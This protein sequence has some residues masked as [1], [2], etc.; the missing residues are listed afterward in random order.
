MATTGER[1]ITPDRCSGLILHIPAAAALQVAGVAAVSEAASVVVAAAV[2]A[3][4]EAEALAAAEPGGVIRSL[5]ESIQRC[6]GHL[7]LD[8]SRF[9]VYS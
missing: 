6:E 3:V 8:L 9:V 2:L 7:G 4:S 5:A 1:D